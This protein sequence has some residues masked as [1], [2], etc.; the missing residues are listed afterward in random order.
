MTF[1]GFP[2][3]VKAEPALAAMADRVTALALSIPESSEV[4]ATSG[5]KTSIAVSFI[6]SAEVNAMTG[7]RISISLLS[8][9]PEEAMSFEESRTKTPE[10][11]RAFEAMM[12]EVIS[13]RLF[14][15]TKAGVLERSEGLKRART[16]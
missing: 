11:S 8:E 15:S 4:R 1:C 12:S 7:R 5:M 14:Q 10:S 6:M 16:K 13:E 9:P 2:I 3:G